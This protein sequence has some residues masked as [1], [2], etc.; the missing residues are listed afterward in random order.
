MAY[1]MLMHIFADHH[2]VLIDAAL[3]GISKKSDLSNA[4]LAIV[5]NSFVASTIEKSRS[6]FGSEHIKTIKNFF[7]DDSIETFVE[8]GACGNAAQL[9]AELLI[10]AGIEVR[11]A[12]MECGTQQSC[13]VVVEANLG[14]GDVILDPLFNLVFRRPDGRLASAEEIGTNWEFYSKQVPQGYDMNMRYERM[15]Y[16]NWNK[17]PFVLPFVKSGLDLI[18]GEDKSNRISLR[19]YIMNI[20]R[21]HEYFSIFMVIALGMF[22]IIDLLKKLPTKKERENG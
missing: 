6:S 16:T 19:V 4:E 7:W 15:T 14:Y 18:L 13:H 9:L 5:L 11:M 1:A 12:Q 22:E 3:M 2:E 21:V 8:G 17:I 20:F 10:H